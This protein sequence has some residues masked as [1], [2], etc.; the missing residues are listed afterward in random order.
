[1][2]HPSGTHLCM[3]HYP[4]QPDDDQQTSFLGNTDIET[5]TIPFNI[6]CGL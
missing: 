5:L 4:P 6:T 1:M 3:L 2:D